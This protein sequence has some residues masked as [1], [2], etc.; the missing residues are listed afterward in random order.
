MTKKTTL[1]MLF[2]FVGTLLFSTTVNSINK[3]NDKV[4]KIISLKH[5][6]SSTR[7]TTSI[8]V[9]VIVNDFT[10]T[11]ITENYTGNVSVSIT[12][13]GGMQAATFYA[14]D[15]GQHTLDISA[16]RT[17][18]YTIRVYLD[19]QTFEGEFEK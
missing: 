10:A 4:D 1:L 12:G 2:C 5:I 19:G 18:T 15:T 7:S 11:I 3:L 16:L 6:R 14:E 8:S 9:I 13:T 17:G